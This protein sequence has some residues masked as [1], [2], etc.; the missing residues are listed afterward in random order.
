MIFYFFGD[1]I[2]TGKHISVHKTWVHKISQELDKKFKNVQVNN[3][4]VNGNTTRMAL[5]RMHNDALSHNPDIIYIQFGLNDCKILDTDYGCE[6]VSKEAYLANIKEMIARSIAAGVKKIIINSS[7]ISNI[8]T[9]LPHSNI[10]YEES[11]TVYY[12]LL[13]TLKRQ[14]SDSVLFI[15]IREYLKNKN[16]SAG[17]YLLNDGLHLNELGHEYYFEYIYPFVENVIMEL[18]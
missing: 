17:N 2:S 11:N 10:T 4:S 7:H 12:N 14:F 15:D 9:R 16:I 8:N 13:L 18:Q 5:E 3:A 1:S 6:R